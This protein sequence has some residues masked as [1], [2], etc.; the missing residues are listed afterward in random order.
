MCLKRTTLGH[1]ACLPVAGVR[2][3]IGGDSRRTV[4]RNLQDI[5]L[6]RDH[7][8]GR[9]HEPNAISTRTRTWTE[10]SWVGER[11]WTIVSCALSLR[12]IC[13]KRRTET[14]HA[15][16]L[17]QGDSRQCPY[18]SKSKF[19]S[20]PGEPV[21]FFDLRLSVVQ[22]LTINRNTSDKTS[23][24]IRCNYGGQ[25]QQGDS[26]ACLWALFHNRPSDL[27]P[28]C[29]QTLTSC[30]STRFHMGSNKSYS[31]ALQTW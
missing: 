13:T 19:K 9:L 18:S 23:D 17:L 12:I 8:L 27:P 20:F 6:N 22:V 24:R 3:R 4:E 25:C 14:C 15:Q 28:W 1:T 31:Y 10:Q 29:C 7:V 16:F 30:S 26:C 5:K 2:E 11:T 21:G